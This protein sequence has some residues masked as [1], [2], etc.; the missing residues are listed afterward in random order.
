MPVIGTAGHVDHGKSSLIEAL[1]GTHPDRL[2]EERERGMTIDLGFAHFPGADG[3]PI[4]VI[5]VPGH[6]RFLRNMVAGAWGLDAA[7]LAVAADDGWMQQSEDHTRV[8]RAMGVGRLAVAVTKTDIA[9]PARVREAMDQARSHCARLGFADAPALAVSAR[10]GEN[11]AALRDLLVRLIEG[12]TP[13]LPYGPGRG[14]PLLYV[15]RVF[16]VKGAGVVVTGTLKGGPVER[17]QEL[18]LLPAGKSVRARG[19]ESY[20]LDVEQAEPGARVALNLHGVEAQEVRR[21]DCLVAPPARAWVD[22]DF[23]LR[24]EPGA[25]EALPGH[26]ELEVAAGT[27]HRLARC[28][29]LDPELVRVQFAEPAALFWNQ[30][31]LLIRHGGSGILGAARAIWAGP[32]DRHARPR[33]AAALRAMPRPLGPRDRARLE[34]AVRGRVL[35]QELEG[36]PPPEAAARGDWLFHAGT[37]AALEEEVLRLAAQPGGTRTAEL[38]GALAGAI[39]SAPAGAL[40]LPSSALEAVV[41]ALVRAGRLAARGGL[42]FA[43]ADPE[44]SLSPFGRQLLA[45]LRRAGGEGLEPKRLKIAGAQKEMATLARSGLAV[46]LD[47]AIYYAADTYRSL[48][49]AILAGRPAGSLLELAAAKQASGLSRKYLIP[50]LNR[51]E[52][53]G[54]VKREGDARRVTRA[55]AAAGTAGTAAGTAGP[56]A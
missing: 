51:M 5:D 27:G 13:E 2:P 31:C 7:L 39:A 18:R 32:A 26:T 45:D 9:A 14:L 23:L 16:T 41:D 36:E 10:S 22:R 3:R 12:V 37:L 50:L 42:L 33:L 24:L 53:D 52:L 54:W 47:G 15:D 6:E 43:G 25:E 44:R 17:G 28:H 35:R 19:L 4:G 29:R 40:D 11:M 1:T 56:P 48:V 49:A 30:P 55:P 46:S 38:A 20:Y 8:L 21:G 34:L